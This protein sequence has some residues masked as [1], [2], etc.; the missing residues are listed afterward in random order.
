MR[1]CRFLVSPLLPARGDCIANYFLSSPCRGSLGDD[2]C[3]A[4]AGSTMQ[5]LVSVQDK[6]GVWRAGGRAVGA[7]RQLGGVILIFSIAFGF[8]P[9]SRHNT[10]R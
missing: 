8:N 7:G 9:H 1:L 4:T 10:L 6:P 5:G 2:A 3:R